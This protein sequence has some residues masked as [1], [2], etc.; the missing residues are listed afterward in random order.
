MRH[1]TPFLALPWEYWKLVTIGS[2]PRLWHSRLAKDRLMLLYFSSKL[3][4]KPE[5]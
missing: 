5:A 4:P 3:H 1:Y 2:H